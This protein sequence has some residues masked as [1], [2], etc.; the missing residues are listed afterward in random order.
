MYKR[1]IDG[2][3]VIGAGLLLAL[4]VCVGLLVHEEIQDRTGD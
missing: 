1:E 2:V 3:L 4:L